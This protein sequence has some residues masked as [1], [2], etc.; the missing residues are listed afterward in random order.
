[1]TGTFDALREA[2]KTGYDTLSILTVAPGTPIAVQLVNLFS[3]VCVFSLNG[4]AMYG[5]FVV[6]SIDQP[7][8]RLFVRTVTDPNCGFRSLVPDSIPKF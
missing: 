6:D 2:P 5:K 1:M 4:V 8:R 7:N 3:N